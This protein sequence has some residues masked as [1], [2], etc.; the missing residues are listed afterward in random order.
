VTSFMICALHSVEWQK[1]YLSGNLSRQ[2][3]S[4]RVQ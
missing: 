1:A 4:I 3:A 2:N